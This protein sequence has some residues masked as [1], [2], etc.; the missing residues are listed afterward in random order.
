MVLARAKFKSGGRRVKAL[1]DI[2]RA[3]LSLR[4]VWYALRRLFR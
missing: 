2:M 4:S 3:A 1:F